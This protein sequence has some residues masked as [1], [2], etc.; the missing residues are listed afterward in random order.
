MILAICLDRLTGK[1]NDDL[2]NYHNC[3]EGALDRPV[4]A[5]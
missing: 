2:K 5:K 4:A 1:R 3:P